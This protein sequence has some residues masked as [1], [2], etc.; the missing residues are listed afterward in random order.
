MFHGINHRVLRFTMA[1]LVSG[2]A[3]DAGDTGAEPLDTEEIATAP[4]ALCAGGCGHE[5]SGGCTGTDPCPCALRP[6]GQGEDE[7]SRR[8]GRGFV[9]KDAFP[10]ASGYPA[11]PLYGGAPFGGAQLGA[12]PYGGYP[13]GGAQLGAPPYGGYPFGG[14]QLGVPPYGGYPYGKYPFGG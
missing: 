3:V 13:F 9:S 6:P 11:A 12:P 5:C 10:G 7:E 14:A 4:E 8:T 1:A 2:C